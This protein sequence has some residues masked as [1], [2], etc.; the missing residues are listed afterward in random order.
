MGNLIQAHGPEGNKEHRRKVHR[1]L[2]ATIHKTH[3]S[4]GCDNEYTSKLH[5]H[6]VNGA[7]KLVHTRRILSSTDT[8][9]WIR[10]RFQVKPATL[11][12]PIDS[13][14]IIMV[15]KFY[16]TR[17]QSGSLSLINVGSDFSL[18][19]VVFFGEIVFTPCVIICFIKRIGHHSKMTGK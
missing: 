13:F 1:Y 10:R 4:A 9:S 8:N 2:I 3:R 11:L 16:G 12:I 14:L 7:A 18:A 15:E 6:P 17:Y 19:R 5:V